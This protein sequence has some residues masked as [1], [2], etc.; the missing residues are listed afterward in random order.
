MMPPKKPTVTPDGDTASRRSARLA[1]QHAADAAPVNQRKRKAAPSEDDK[2]GKKPKTKTSQGKGKAAPTAADRPSKKNKIAVPPRSPKPSRRAATEGAR[3]LA[4]TIAILAPKRKVSKGK[5]TPAQAKAKNPNATSTTGKKPAEKKA[6]VTNAGVKKSTKKKKTTSKPKKAIK[7]RA[8]AKQ[9]SETKTTEEEQLPDQ[10]STAGNVSKEKTTEGQDSRPETTKNTVKETPAGKTVPQKQAF[11]REPESAIEGTIADRAKESTPNTDKSEKENDGTNARQPSADSQVP[12]MSTSKE[13]TTAPEEISTEETE[14]EKTAQRQTQSEGDGDVPK[15]RDSQEKDSGILSPA[16]LEKVL[17]RNADK[18]VTRSDARARSL[19][20]EDAK[21]TNTKVPTVERANSEPA[22]NRDVNEREPLRLDPPKVRIGGDDFDDREINGLVNFH[23]SCFANATFQLLDAALSGYNHDELFGRIDENIRRFRTLAAAPDITGVPGFNDVLRKDDVDETDEEREKDKKLVRDI[24]EEAAKQAQRNNDAQRQDDVNTVRHF[25]VFLDELGTLRGPDDEYISAFLFQ[26]IVAYGKIAHGSYKQDTVGDRVRMDGRFQQDAHEFYMILHSA[27]FREN[28]AT[29]AQAVRKIFEVEKSITRRCTDCSYRSLPEYDITN[30]HDIIVPRPQKD[31][32]IELK[33][34]FQR[35]LRDTTDATCPQCSGGRL[36]T[37]VE[38]QELPERLV[39]HMNRHG[40]RKKAYKKKTSISLGDKRLRINGWEYNLS[41]VVLHDGPGPHQGH[42]TSLRKHNDQW[43]FIS[44]KR[45]A[46]IPSI[47]D[48]IDRSH[49]ETC[50]LLY[51]K[52]K[53]ISDEAQIGVAERDS[54]DV[55]KPFGRSDVPSDSYDS[56]F[57]DD[58]DSERD[59]NG[60][61]NW[62]QACFANAA[63]HVFD[64]AFSGYDLNWLLGEGDSS[65]RRFNCL[66]A[67]RDIQGRSG[68]REYLRKDELRPFIR[69]DT[70]EAKKIAVREDIRDA[71]AQGQ[72]HDTSVARH[73]RILL[74]ELGAI[75]KEHDQYISPYLFQSVYT[76]GIA[77]NET[78]AAAVATRHSMSGK[79][80]RDSFLYWQGLLDALLG[81]LD[82]ATSQNLRQLFEIITTITLKCGTCAYGR[83][84]VATSNS[85][86]VTVPDAG[87]DVEIQDL[88]EKAWLHQKDLQCPRCPGRPL[89]VQETKFKSLPENIVIGVLRDGMRNG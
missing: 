74:E 1:D 51:K 37:Q 43:H 52:G 4:E 71:A 73:F 47:D 67:H 79:S 11:A 70:T 13:G 61:I 18:P 78:N 86:Q 24:I 6:G 26:S 62:S 82:T 60:L 77:E 8:A 57:P 76:F 19:S 80:E 35:A 72:F 81:D 17:E 66:E 36:Y 49:G 25:R 89:L 39:I 88:L 48:Y 2:P 75:R 69:D 9:I 59:I 33:D 44:D 84:R 3:K 53:F 40:F 65:I 15:E 42:Y 55:S 87:A 41:A 56:S 29:R 20:L 50:L 14:K 16:S 23:A 63:V 45:C 85:L 46:K 30:F 22:R 31:V 7:R 5:A 54:Q 32:T 38:F 83:T 58:D 28:I 34:L 12:R 27:L 10:E 64:A 68:Y 21:A